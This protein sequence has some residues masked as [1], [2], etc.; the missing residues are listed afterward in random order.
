MKKID[1]YIIK[2][3]L[4][5][6]IYS[7]ILIISIAVVFDLSEKLDDFIEKHASL[8]AIIF[9]YYF[10]FIP[11]YVNLFSA[12]FTF[13]SVLFFTS[14]M[15]Y[16]YEIVAMLSNGISYRRIMRPYMISAALLAILT[17]YLINFIIPNANKVR[18]AFENTYIKSPYKNKDNN[19]HRQISPGV[20]IYMEGYNNQINMGYKFSMERFEKHK[21]VSKLLSEYI[22]WDTTKHK[23]TVNNYYIRKFTDTNEKIITG[24]RMDTVFN[25]QPEDFSRRQNVVQSMNLY[26][27]NKYIDGQLMEG[28][29]S[30]ESS[31]IEKYRRYS[32]PFSTFI[33][34]LIGVSVASRQSKGGIGLHIGIGLGITATYILFMQITSQFAISGSVSPLLAVWI[35]NII[36][37]VVALILY[38]LAPK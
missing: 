13:I 29:T 31:L 8:H 12:F 28:S 25:L 23:W 7:I 33:L 35:P 3:F 1:I 19:I 15:S 10:N 21:L 20:F 24:V 32:Y 22:M 9:D 38:K 17:F 34:T 26:E 5:T 14:Q 6:Y 2:K 4:G 27:L 11:Y 30:V 18:L 16:N 36:F 37:S